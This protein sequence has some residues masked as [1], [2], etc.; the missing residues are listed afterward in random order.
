MHNNQNLLLNK[1]QFIQAVRSLQAD[2]VLVDL[3]PRMDFETIDYFVN[4]DTNVL[5]TTPES[6]ALQNGIAFLKSVFKRK[7]ETAVQ[8][9][10]HKNIGHFFEHIDNE[11]PLVKQTVEILEKLS[12]PGEE[13]VRRTLASFNTKILFNMVRPGESLRPLRMMRKYLDRELGIKAEM[14]GDVLYDSSVHHLLRQQK[15]SALTHSSSTIFENVCRLSGKMQRGAFNQPVN[16]IRF[17][18]PIRKVHSKDIIC[19][20]W[21]GSWQDCGFKNPG[22]GCPVKNIN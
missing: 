15:L 9:L 13:I 14:V 1:I 18:N 3:G 22:S 4:A 10:L 12:L 7:I 2:Y 8:T 17:S 5:V 19:G 6:T 16:T 20:T 21:C 11:L